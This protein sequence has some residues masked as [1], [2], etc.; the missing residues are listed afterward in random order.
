[1]RYDKESNRRIALQHTS[2]M[3]RKYGEETAKSIAYSRIYSQA[4]KKPQSNGNGTIT[5]ENLDTVSSAFR[6]SGKVAVLNFASY[7]NPGGQFING[8]MAQEEALCH[9]SNLYNIL[10]QFQ[11]YYSWNSKHLNRGL[12]LN[13]AIYTP[14]VIFEN[15]SE[16]RKFDVITCAAP[17][18][19]L[20]R[21]GNFTAEENKKILYDRIRFVLDI[22]EE[23]QVETLILGAWGCGVF[24]QDPKEVLD[25]IL[26][27]AKGR[28][29]NIVLAVPGSDRNAE[30]FNVC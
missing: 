25:G 24:R 13:R 16:T 8:S 20:I 10:K 12:Y 7:K 27:G 3:Y 29:L 6:H 9:K 18:K 1:M 21:Y 17:N 4:V 19:S 28:A 2:E 26:E 23:N 14:G 11:E 5:F 15:G 22:A 30:V